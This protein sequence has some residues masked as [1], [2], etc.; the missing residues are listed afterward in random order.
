MTSR[1]M[2]EMGRTRSIASVEPSLRPD[3]PAQVRAADPEQTM[4]FRQADLDL[5]EF[6]LGKPPL[7]R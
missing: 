7:D 3:P 2:G 4:T 1:S 5:L 6:A